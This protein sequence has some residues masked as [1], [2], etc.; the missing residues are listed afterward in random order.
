MEYQFNKERHL[1]QIK[2]DDKWKNLTGCTTVLSVVAK[3]ALIPWASKMAVEHI[4]A[5]AKKEMLPVPEGEKA[6]EYNYIV[7]EKLLE[8]AKSAHSKRKEKAGEWGTGTHAEVERYITDKIAGK[9]SAGYSK[10]IKNFIDWSEKNKVKFLET[11]KNIYSEKLFIGGIVDFVCEIDGKIWIGDIKT[12][13]SGIY[14]ENFWQC[15]GYD[16]M[17][18]EMGLYPVI[19][20]YLILNIK[21]N[22]EFNEKRSVSLSENQEAFLSCLKIYRIQEKLKNIIK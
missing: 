19:G 11:E 20:G 2:I 14:P 21:E 7:S 5:N 9:V 10:R 18:I 4:R 22:G 1:H 12:S 13:N 15:A 17:L 8:E 16:L 3:P 6:T